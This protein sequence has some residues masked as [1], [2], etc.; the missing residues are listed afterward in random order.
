[1]VFNNNSLCSTCIHKT[2]CSLT[3]NKN[4]IWACSEYEKKDLLET[5]AISGFNF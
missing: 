1:M 3:S 5:N 4:A 2:D